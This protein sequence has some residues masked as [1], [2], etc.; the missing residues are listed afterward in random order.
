MKL[1]IP[2]WDDVCMKVTPS[3]AFLSRK[4]F[5][6]PTENKLSKISSA[7]ALRNYILSIT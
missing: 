4:E 5:A 7:K 2:K 6:L 3:I 1:L